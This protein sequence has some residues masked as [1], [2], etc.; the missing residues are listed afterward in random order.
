MIDLPTGFPMYC[1]DLKQML[2]E[3]IGAFRSN[4]GYFDLEKHGMKEHFEDLS[5]APLEYKLELFKKYHSK[6]P[7]QDNEHNALDDAKWNKKLYDFVNFL[8]NKTEL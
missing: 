8:T 7:K 2:D 6:Y 4:I 5:T 3:K 1:R